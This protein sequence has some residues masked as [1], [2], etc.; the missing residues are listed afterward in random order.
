MPLSGRARKPVCRLSAGAAPLIWSKNCPDAVT[1]RGFQEWTGEAW[2]SVGPNVSVPLADVLEEG[3]W[4][5]SHFQP[6][7]TSMCVRTFRPSPLAGNHPMLL[8][9]PLTWKNY[10]KHSFK[11]ADSSAIF[12]APSERVLVVR[13]PLPL[14]DSS[15]GTVCPE[16]CFLRLQAGLRQQRW[17]S[18]GG[19][20][21]AVSRVLGACGVAPAGVAV[22]LSSSAW[23]TP[24]LAGLVW[25]RCWRAKAGRPQG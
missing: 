15:A 13:D 2:S 16:R 1:Q 4:E 18:W 9:A 11:R 17:S 24:S 10:G 12:W 5:T 14:A 7:A 22:T 25:R 21:W 8:K 19:D 20:I 6:S 23:A 3:L